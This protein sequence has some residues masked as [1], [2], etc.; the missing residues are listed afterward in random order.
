MQKIKFMLEYNCIPIWLYDSEGN[1]IGPE[2]PE[3]LSNDH[4]FVALINQ[5]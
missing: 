4:E 5:V 3:E 2:L 1:L